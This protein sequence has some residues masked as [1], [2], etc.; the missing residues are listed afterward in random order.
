MNTSLRLVSASLGMLACLGAGGCGNNATRPL[1]IGNAHQMGDLY[2]NGALTDTH[3]NR[4][5]VDVVPGVS[6]TM[7]LV[8]DSWSRAGGYLA[9]TGMTMGGD[10]GVVRSSYRFAFTDCMGHFIGR[11][12]HD[13][14]ATTNA[15]LD[16][17]WTEMPFGWMAQW[18]GRS[19][20]GYVIKP[21]GRI[22]GGS[23]G[24]VG[25]VA[26]GTAF[27][28]VEGGGRAVLGIG[29]IAVMGTAYPVA[30]IVWQQ[31]AYIFSVINRE[32]DLKQ[33]GK[34]GLHVVS[35]GEPDLTKRDQL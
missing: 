11:G 14:Y 13:D 35:Y 32:P 6:P 23:V 34:W 5:N 4:W 17:L 28:A 7:A 31:P 12:I 19:T 33:D 3:G 29:D 30:R 16:E 27:G 24:S 26:L 9:N 15:Q 2:W 20:W 22:I 25:G 18:A 1:V 10:D 8:G 21:I